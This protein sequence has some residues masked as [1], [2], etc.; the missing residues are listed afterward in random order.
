MNLFWYDVV[1]G[2]CFFL[3]ILYVFLG[4]GTT[5]QGV[6]LLVGG[7]KPPGVQVGEHHTQLA[8]VGKGNVR[9]VSREYLTVYSLSRREKNHV[10]S[11]N[12]FNIFSYYSILEHIWYLI[13]CEQCAIDIQFAF[14]RDDIT[15]VFKNWA[16]AD[17]RQVEN[18]CSLKTIWRSHGLSCRFLDLC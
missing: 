3:A 15:S 7:K 9:Q 18:R 14:I 8:Q 12:F 17:I 2:T 10:V 16:I 13:C 6:S 11:P 5:N 1:S 4:M